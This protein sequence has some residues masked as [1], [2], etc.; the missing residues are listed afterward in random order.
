MEL[1]NYAV[2]STDGNF[3]GA[4]RDRIE[5]GLRRVHERADFD[6]N[7]ELFRA[8][9]LGAFV[10][11][12]SLDETVVEAIAATVPSAV[13]V[14]AE[15]AA[16]AS[17]FVSRFQSVPLLKDPGERYL[18]L[19]LGIARHFAH[20]TDREATQR[21]VVRTTALRYQRLLE[22]LPD[23]VYKVDP[24][25][26]FTY[27]NGAISTLGYE[28][29]DLL[30]KHFSTILSDGEIERVGR[31][32]VIDQIRESGAIPTTAPLLFDERRAGERKTRGLNVQLQ[33][34][35]PGL[36]GSVTVHADVL[37]Y[38]E[39][40]ATGDYRKRE[41]SLQFTGTVGIIRDST[42]RVLLQRNLERLSQVVERSRQAVVIVNAA[43]AMIYANTAFYREA[44]GE[45]RHLTDRSIEGVA[46]GTHLSWA[47]V[48]EALESD[49]FF[50]ADVKLPS[51]RGEDGDGLRWFEVT[52]YPVHLSGN[53]PD[54]F[55]IF[56]RD[57]HARKIREEELAAALSRQEAYLREVHHRVKNNL[58]VVMSLF[59]LEDECLSQ[60]R[61]SRRRRLCRL[62][63]TPNCTGDRAD[64]PVTGRRDPPRTRRR[65]APFRTR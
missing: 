42:E 33:R 20:V 60:Q 46:W 58:Q 17:S 48:A 41:E 45:P 39:V 24:D 40:A 14:R 63:T 37:A 22:A 64:T 36:D 2:I 29:G 27:L 11:L 3:R 31:E 4:I 1:Q 12:D 25:G 38:G 8:G 55:V 44:P 32:H 56:Q 9:L 53:T 5:S 21:D 30:G 61:D 10:D 18:E 23:I 43:G 51:A 6:L 57:I 52:A 34:K 19:I 16:A 15:L 59:A 54:E 49:E 50:A 35:H 62:S 7:D 65:R 47:R 28:P 13:A 26:R